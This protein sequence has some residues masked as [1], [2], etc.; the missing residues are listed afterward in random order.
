MSD[1]VSRLFLSCTHK[2]VLQNFVVVVV[3]VKFLK[4]FCN[5]IGISNSGAT[6]NLSVR[7]FVSVQSGCYDKIPQTGWLVD[8]RNLFLSSGGQEVQDEG[9]CMVW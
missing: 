3:V 8:N 7:K 1:P 2:K 5:Q 9:V 6:G 4:H